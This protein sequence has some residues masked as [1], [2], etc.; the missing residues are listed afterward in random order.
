MKPQHQSALLI[1]FAAADVSISV[2]SIGFYSTRSFDYK[3]IVKCLTFADG[4]DYFISPVDF[5]VLAFLRLAFIVIPLVLIARRRDGV[6]KAM[7]MPMIGFAT[8]CYSYALVK[9]L[10]FS[11]NPEL[12][13]YPGVW[14]S[15]LWSVAATLLF[16]LIW[17]FV[18]TAHNFGYQRLTSERLENDGFSSE[19]SS[20]TAE[21]SG[22]FPPILL[23][24]STIQH[25]QTLL[26]YC[27]NQWLLFTLGFVF[28][29]IYAVVRVF[30]PAYMGQVISHVVEKAGTEALLRSVLVIGALAVASALFGGLLGGCFD[31]ATAL[32]NRQVRLDLFRSL[33][34]QETAFFDMT[35][36]G[37]M[38]SRLTADCQTMSTAVSSNLNVFLRNGVMLVGALVFMFAMSW[39]L[40]LVTFIAVPFIGFIT[41]WYATFYDKIM[42]KSQATVASANNVAHEVLSTIRTVRSFACERREASRFEGKLD[43]TLKMDRKKALA[44]AGFA[45]NYELCDNVILVS[46]L[47]YGGHLVLSDM[48]TTAQLITFLL[49]QL[50]LGENVNNI[51]NVVS[52]L[53]QCVGASRKV[54][55]YMHRK[56]AIPNDGDLKPV[57]SGRIEFRDVHF[58]YPSRPGSEVLKG[59]N[60]IVEAGRTTALVGPSGAGKSS[61]VS[62]IEH[63]YEPTS[64]EITIDGVGIKNISHTFYH[65][66]VALVAQE[67]VL[68]NGSVRFNITYGC[69]WATED[70][71]LRASQMAN[72]HNFITEL[73]H[74]YDT[75]CGDKGVQLSGGQKQRIAIARALIRNPAVLIL[76]EATS[77]L[78]ALSEA[79]VQEALNRCSKERT[80]FII[81]HRLSTIENAHHIAVINRGRLEQFGSHTELIADVDGLYH[82]LV[83]KQILTARIE[84]S[85]A[86]DLIESYS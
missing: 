3:S 75:N 69:E 36:P 70:D 17:C 33:V 13:R 4:Y 30:M 59:L 57:V 26:R 1:L 6:A 43:E 81:A 46:V 73:E 71:M 85:D 65:Q 12:M 27:M 41:K 58:T 19:A 22:L 7:L 11:E 18:L 66:K 48:M 15:L 77:A 37:E 16:S 67:P 28:L 84:S 2:L 80:V 38:V 62:L 44:H 55:E 32:V 31:Y 45:F 35:K 53:M 21:E 49:Y 68:Y 76:D 63:F 29:V 72:A 42:E 74:G 8:F 79:L 60:L 47:F 34:K 82:S 25:I 14:C 54:I 39:R 24:R 5:V 86:E 83:S 51:G 40:S 10:A 23:R 64:G 56:P 20:E 78:D 9:F 50:Q 52:G 61:I